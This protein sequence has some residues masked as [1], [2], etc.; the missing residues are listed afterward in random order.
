MDWSVAGVSVIGASHIARGTTCQDAH[1]YR[2]PGPGVL[3]IA[4][5]DGAGS[6]PRSDEGAW[7]AVHRAAATLERLAGSQQSTDGRST[8]VEDLSV[9]MS[10]A[11]GEARAALEYLAVEESDPLKFFHCT[12]CCVLAV[13]DRFVVGQIGDGV[14]VARSPDGGLFTAGEPQRGEYANEAYFLTMDG[15]L[16]LVAISAF[17]DAVDGLA[18]TSDGLLRLALDM[19]SQ[20]PHAPFFEPLFKYLESATDSSVAR[21]ELARFLAS[22]RV[23]ART[24]DDKTLVLATRRA[25]GE[26]AGSQ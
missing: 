3:V 4:V 15:A 11:F 23:T 18:V 26:G 7:V 6:A 5:A 21:A 8:Q 16:D 12:L 19:R 13:D 20:E 2:Q 9:A 1:C 17:E 10:T 25:T 14:C 24:D 22:D